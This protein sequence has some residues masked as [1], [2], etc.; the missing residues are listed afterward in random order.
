MN[1]KDAKAGNCEWAKLASESEEGRKVLPP[2]EEGDVTI[3]NV[4]LLLAH[5]INDSKYNV[6]KEH[7]LYFESSRDFLLNKQGML[8]E[9]LRIVH[10]DDMERCLWKLRD[11]VFNGSL[12]TLAYMRRM[13]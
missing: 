3:E 12:D 10:D 2:L 11:F 9:W 4:T 7:R 8:E 5:L 13:V 1:D 6:A